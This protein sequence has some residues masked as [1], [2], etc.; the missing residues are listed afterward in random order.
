MEALAKWGAVAPKINTNI[1][2]NEQIMETN[3][4][5]NSSNLI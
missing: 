4:E 3:M 2:I 1:L 5:G